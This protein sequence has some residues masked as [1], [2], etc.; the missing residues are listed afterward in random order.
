MPRLL[1]GTSWMPVPKNRVQW[2]KIEFFHLW[3]KCISDLIW[4][5]QCAPRFTK[6]I[7]PPWH[8]LWKLCKPVP[9]WIHNAHAPNVGLLPGCAMHMHKM[10][11]YFRVR[12]HIRSWNARSVLGGKL[13][14]PRPI[15]PGISLHLAKI[16]W[17]EVYYLPVNVQ[18]VRAL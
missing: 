17:T 1:I 5:Y 8:F 16:T 6:L 4:I 12:M 13:R 9:S 3:H 14:K 15:F 18:A 2:V 10:Q 7:L 11:V